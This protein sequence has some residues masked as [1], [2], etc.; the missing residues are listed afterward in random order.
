M[1]VKRRGLATLQ[2][3]TEV[4]ENTET[5]TTVASV[6]GNLALSPYIHENIVRTGNSSLY[7]CVCLGRCVFVW[8]GVH[9][10][11]RVCVGVVGV[12]V[13]L[14]VCACVGVRVCVCVAYDFEQV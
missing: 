1:F 5:F 10:C 12:C 4:Y 3:V 14:G 2:R 11:A 9:V 7:V 13:C 6:L 8:V